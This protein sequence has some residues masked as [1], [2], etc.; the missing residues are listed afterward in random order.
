MENLS[1]GTLFYHK[2]PSHHD[3]ISSKENTCVLASEEA[4][5]EVYENVLESKMKNP[6]A[7]KAE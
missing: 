6:A 7:R 1:L 5:I 3:C 4:T 2:N